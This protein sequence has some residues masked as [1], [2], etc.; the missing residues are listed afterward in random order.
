MDMESLKKQNM[1]SAVPIE[2]RSTAS[3]SSLYYEKEGI[4]V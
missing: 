3:F 2:D 1:G 4:F